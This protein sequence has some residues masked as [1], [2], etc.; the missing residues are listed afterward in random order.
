MALQERLST[1]FASGLT[2]LLLAAA[3]VAPVLADLDADGFDG[4]ELIVPALILA[5]VVAVGMVAWRARRAG[6]RA[7]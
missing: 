1:L 2:A 4:D 3:W 5:A 6:P 7:E